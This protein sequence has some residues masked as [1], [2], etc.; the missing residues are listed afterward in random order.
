M[1]RE[2]FLSLEQR[3]E[4]PPSS[5]ER[6]MIYGTAASRGVFPLHRRQKKS[7]EKE[8]KKEPFLNCDD[9]RNIG[10]GERTKPPDRLPTKGTRGV[11]FSLKS[12]IFP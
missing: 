2:G 9:E 8:S 6:K 3:K 1:K 10:L 11:S 12:P 4:A 7:R 5:N